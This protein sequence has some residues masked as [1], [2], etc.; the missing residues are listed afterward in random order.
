MKVDYLKSARVQRPLQYTIPR[1]LLAFLRRNVQRSPETLLCLRNGSE[2]CASEAKNNSLEN[3]VGFVFFGFKV[4]YQ[5]IEIVICLKAICLK[6][7]RGFTYLW[8]HPSS[9][10]PIQ[11]NLRNVVTSKLLIWHLKTPI[12]CNNSTLTFRKHYT[13]CT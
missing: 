6:I 4:V 12:L 10:K 13:H 9:S 5:E 7:T 3:V 2:L 8:R 1:T 11:C